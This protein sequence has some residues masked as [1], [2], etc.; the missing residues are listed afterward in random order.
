[1]HKRMIGVFCV[2]GLLSSLLLFRMGVIMM[3]PYYQE[4]GNQQATQT[5][6][7]EIKRG[8][9]YDHNFTPL[10]NRQTRPMAAMLLTEENV[11]EVQQLTD[12]SEEQ[13]MERLKTGKPF[14]TPMNQTTAYDKNIFPFLQYD[15][16]EQP[17][18][19]PH[20]I[21]YL[22]DGAGA[23]GIEKAYDA[24]LTEATRQLLVTYQTDARGR[25]LKTELPIISEHGTGDGVVL[26]LDEQIQFLCQQAEASI[27]RGA[28]VVMEVETGKLRGVA[29]FPSYDVNHLTAALQDEDS[30]LLNRAFSPLSVGSV[31]KVA[32]AAAALEQGI[33]PQTTY[34]CTGSYQL[35]ETVM[36]CVNRNGHGV[37]T[38]EQALQNS[39]NPYFI[40]LGLQLNQEQ[41][42]PLLRSLSFGKKTELAP[43]FS[44][45]RGRLPEPGMTMGELA[46]LSFG[47]GELLATPVQVAQ[48]MS[49]VANGGTTPTPALVEGTVS[50]ELAWLSREQ[51]WLGITSL[52]K[53]TT[54]SLQRYLTGGNRREQS[55]AKPHFTTAGGKTS[56]AQTGTFD[57]NGEEIYLGWYAGFVPAKKPKYAVVVVAEDALSGNRSAGPVF[58]KISDQ[59]FL[60]GKLG[61]D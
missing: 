24:F 21:G 11:T 29:S 44:T 23:T 12:L 22:S 9:I 8:T 56:T 20:L 33:S 15:R 50:E 43:G 55:L 30:P 17:Q 28:V 47:Q 14:F 34:C 2:L 35:G 4:V 45:A 48:M 39:C 31:F 36:R 1:M 37:Q 46:N 57:A 13:R 26:T 61:S 32:I 3:N 19:A 6:K 54:S 53:E 58:A 49:A 16:Y 18:I 52:K 7:Q 51:P 10:T 60:L 5:L 40:H 38:L 59:L 42:L 41:L 27:K 25:P